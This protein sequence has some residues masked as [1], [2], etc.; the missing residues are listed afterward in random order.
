MHVDGRAKDNISKERFPG[1]PSLDLKWEDKTYKL[2]RT[3][4]L[5]LLIFSA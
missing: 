3:I 5:H 1:V 4:L 2:K